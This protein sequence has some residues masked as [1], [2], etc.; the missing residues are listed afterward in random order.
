MKFIHNAKECMLIALFWLFVFLCEPLY[1]YYVTSDGH[2]AFDWNKVLVQ[3]GL[4]TAFLLLFLL[5][6]F[7]LVPVFVIRKQLWY[8]VSCTIFSLLVFAVFLYFYSLYHHPVH[9]PVMQHPPLLSPPNVARLVIAALMVFADL[10]VLA[11]FNAHRLRE[12]LLLLEKQTLGQELS[13]LRYQINPHFFMNTLNNIHVLVDVDQERAKRAIIELS[14]MMRYSLYECNAPIVPLQPEIRFLELFISL[15]KLRFNDKVRLS[16]SL[17]E[18]TPPHAMLPPM[19]LATFVENAFKH[20][21]SYRY[22]SYIE[23][24]MSIEEE[25]RVLHFHCENSRHAEATSD[26][27]HGIGLANVRK[28]LDLQYADAYKLDID[29]DDAERF[30]VD[31]V[32]PL[33]GGIENETLDT[34]HL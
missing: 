21:I 31:L 10:G 30:A 6:H 14:N 12:K 26:G 15:M 20:G 19:L 8:Y 16:V 4:N 11:W 7:V 2:M 32:L 22:P 23:I 24:A 34:T 33:H 27:R 25:G 28:R 13:H 9:H 3:W 1:M 29:R 17:P 18:S 5:H